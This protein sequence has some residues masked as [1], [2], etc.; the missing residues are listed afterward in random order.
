MRI[1][2]WSSDVC[3]SDLAD[4]VVFV[5]IHA[6][7]LLSG[8]RDDRGGDGIG[9]NR[10]IAAETAVEERVGERRGDRRQSLGEALRPRPV[11][12][13]QPRTDKIEAFEAERAKVV[14]GLAL[15]WDEHT[16]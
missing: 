15:R 2:D 12:A 11:A 1:S 9:R 3:S 7:T 10:A 4:R 6:R 16:Y 5:D 8:Q 14:L 13:Q